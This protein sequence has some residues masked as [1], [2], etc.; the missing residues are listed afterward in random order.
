MTFQNFIESLKDN[1]P[2]TGLSV[3]LQALWWDAKGEWKQ[4]H[5]LIDHLED[6][7]SAHVHAYL[8]RVEGDSWNARY[9]YG[10][11]KQTEFKGSLED[12][13]KYLV[14]LYL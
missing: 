8:H 1:Q 14:E 13:W 6:R 7:D 3:V 5:D 10:R 2:L 9:W 12:E 4:A 11:A